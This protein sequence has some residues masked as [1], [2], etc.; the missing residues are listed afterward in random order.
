[1]DNKFIISSL[2]FSAL[3]LSACGGDGGS[4]DTSPT[5][6]G[7]VNFTVAAPLNLAATNTDQAAAEGVASTAS[8]S[9]GG[10]AKGTVGSQKTNS[11]IISLISNF[12]AQVNR[13]NKIVTSGPLACDVGGTSEVSID[14]VTFAFTASFNNCSEYGEVLNGNLTGSFNEGSVSTVFTITFSNFSINSTSINGAFTM[15]MSGQMV[16]TSTDFSGFERNFVNGSNMTINMNYKGRTVTL[17]NFTMTYDD[18]FLASPS[19]DISTFEYDMNSAGLNG[20]LH[21]TTTE[22]VYQYYT[23]DYPYAGKVKLSGANNASMLITV[24]DATNITLEK[25][26]NGDGIYESSSNLTW[27]QLNDFL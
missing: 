8:S 17:G 5:P 13:R 10:A 15:A 3:T 1:M 24:L 4:D 2:L 19:Y 7:T 6:N 25:D 9:I 27:S 22:A 16:I 18:Y 21:V 12:K 14:D 23:D 11:R 20:S 26:V